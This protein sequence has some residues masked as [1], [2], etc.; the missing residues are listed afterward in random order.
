MESHTRA[1]LPTAGWSR[2][3]LLTSGTIKA[4]MSAAMFQT[5]CSTPSV[6]CFQF[7]QQQT[8]Q[9]LYFLPCLTIEEI[10]AGKSGEPRD[11]A[12][13]RNSVLLGSIIYCPSTTQFHFLTWLWRWVLFCTS[14]YPILLDSPWVTF[15]SVWFVFAISIHSH[16]PLPTPRPTL[17]FLVGEAWGAFRK[18]M[19][20]FSPYDDKRGMGC[21]EKFLQQSPCPPS[22]QGWDGSVR[23]QRILCRSL[24]SEWWQQLSDA[25]PQ[26][27]Q[28]EA[29][30]QS[31]Q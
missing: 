28:L 25:A 1:G 29:D 27:W 10:G 30:T 15:D 22:G 6:Y 17:Y 14:S 20:F 5:L 2:A 23:L 21:K 4:T 16:G 18:W 26:L 8:L 19:L 31:F 3:W 7:S 9:C 12:G 11:L 24:S 13:N